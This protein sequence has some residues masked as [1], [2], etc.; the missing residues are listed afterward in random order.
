M[1]K[2]Y[3]MKG[4]NKF[5]RFCPKCIIHDTFFEGGGSWISDSCPKC[6]GTECIMYQNLTLVQKFKARKKF[7]I[8][9][10]K[11]EY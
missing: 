5:E 2:D 7:D 10:R 6:G 4:F 9:V 8:M 1:A 11:R 3:I